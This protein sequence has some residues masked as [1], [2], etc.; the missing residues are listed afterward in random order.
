MPRAR[1]V[2]AAA[3]AGA[4]TFPSATNRELCPGN[5]LGELAYSM[6]PP[7]LR[8]SSYIHFP[9]FCSALPGT[10]HAKRRDRLSQDQ[11]HLLDELGFCWSV[12]SAM[13]ETVEAAKLPHLASLVSGSDA[14]PPADCGNPAV[15]F[16]RDMEDER[17]G[18]GVVWWDQ[19][20]ALTMQYSDAA[21][22]PKASAWGAWLRKQRHDLSDLERLAQPEQPQQLQSSM[23]ER[24][25]E[26]LVP[27]PKHDPNQSPQLPQLELHRR[28]EALRMWDRRWD[29]TEHDHRWN[30]RF[31]QLV[32]YRR[33]HGDCCVPISYSVVPGLGPWVSAQRKSLRHV[34][35]R[36]HEDRHQQR[37]QTAPSSRQLWRITQ[38]DSIGFV[39][40]MQDLL[41][42]QWKLLASGDDPVVSRTGSS[43]NHSI[44]AP[45]ACTRKAAQP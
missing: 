42:S 9:P 14:T 29:W 15:A 44:G 13:G 5:A 8:S 24:H 21:S 43:I 18:D 4:F 45:F 2:G 28:R 23:E 31:G 41:E 6:P 40:C 32:T 17:V 20:R 12:T 3:T 7:P 37:T 34:R 16:H 36:R 39:W 35:E 27:W 1:R 33:K 19:H 22:V 11:V 38:L 26:S 10:V 30:D 25:E